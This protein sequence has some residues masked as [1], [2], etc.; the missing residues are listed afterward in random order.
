MKKLTVVLDERLLEQAQEMSGLKTQRGVIEKAL[1]D[2]VVRRNMELL[3][4][5]LGTYELNWT[6]GELK[7]VRRARKF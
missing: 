1:R 2:Y 6:L 7:K 3:R 4:E 5:E